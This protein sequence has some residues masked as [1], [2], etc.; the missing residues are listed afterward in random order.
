M[1]IVAD[2]LEVRHDTQNEDDR[3]EQK[4]DHQVAEHREGLRS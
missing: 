3:G 1:Q 4:Y 2:K